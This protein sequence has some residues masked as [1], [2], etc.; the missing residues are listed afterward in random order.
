MKTTITLLILT[1]ISLTGFGQVY[2]PFP[3]SNAMWRENSGGFQCSCCSDFQYTITGDTVINTFTYHKLQKTGVKYLEDWI[4]NCTSNIA[5][6]INQYAGCFR[7]DSSNKLVYFIFPLTSIDTVLYDF[8][9][10]IGDTVPPSPLNDNG[11][12]VNIVTDIDSVYLGGVYRKRFQLDSCTFP[13]Q[14]YYI[15]GI[16][17][18]F[19]LLSPTGCP[20]EEIY[21]LLCYTENSLTVFPNNTTTCSIVT[22]VNET[23]QINNKFSIFPN[24]TTGTLFITTELQSYDISIFNSTGQLIQKRKIISNSILL[25]ISDLPTGL[26]LIHFS[27]NNKELY[28]QT[29]VR[30]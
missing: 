26:F 28:K 12:I 27:E 15:E 25:D 2:K 30:Q 11:N 18:T 29:I 6:G 23:T 17:S 20:F 19:G 3:T 7:N 21:N 10:S 14:L 13:Q 8:N 4:G 5:Y 9:L 1:C 24:P 22:S 16:G